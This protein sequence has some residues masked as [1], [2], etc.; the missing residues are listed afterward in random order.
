M[1]LSV[2]VQDA[3]GT[4][5]NVSLK[6]EKDGSIP[7]GTELGSLSFRGRLVLLPHHVR[8]PFHPALVFASTVQYPVGSV[9][10]SRVFVENIK[11]TTLSNRS[12]TSKECRRIEH[13]SRPGTRCQTYR[14]ATSLCVVLSLDRSGVLRK[15]LHGEAPFAGC[16][17]SSTAWVNASYRQ[18]TPSRLSNRRVSVSTHPPKQPSV[19][20]PTFRT[21]QIIPVTVRIAGDPM[22]TVMHLTNGMGIGMTQFDVLIQAQELLGIGLVLLLPFLL[23]YFGCCSD[24][25]ERVAWRTRRALNTR[26][27]GGHV[28]ADLY[29]REGRPPKY[30]SGA[31]APLPPRAANVL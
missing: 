11:L 13:G 2:G 16:I 19:D 6:A 17:R 27:G 20:F 14:V 26:D 25:E 9:V 28:R 24:E 21:A 7:I 3:G 23:V 5:S 10:A 29:P 1:R 15:P 4:I 22:L 31:H 30:E 12:V 8:L 18:V